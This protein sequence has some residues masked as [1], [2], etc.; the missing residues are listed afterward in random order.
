MLSLLTDDVERWEAGNSHP[1][2]G[3]Q[4]FG[5][6]IRPGPN[7]VG[8]RG[9]IRRMTE[10][11]NVVVAEGWVEVSL[12]DGGKVPVRYCDVFEFEGGKI[13]KLTAFSAPVK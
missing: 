11:G 7:V 4:E 8:L 12:N 13:R 9:T 2:R 6:N 5:Q 10:Q 1:W 3:K